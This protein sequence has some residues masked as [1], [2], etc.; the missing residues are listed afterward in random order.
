MAGC[1]SELADAGTELPECRWWANRRGDPGTR[2]VADAVTV[3]H[4]RWTAPM[5]TGI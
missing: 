5:H 2:P 3:R 1:G 4:L